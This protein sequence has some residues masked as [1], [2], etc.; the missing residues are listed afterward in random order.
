MAELKEIANVVWL[1]IGGG[2]DESRITLDEILVVA[3]VEYAFQ[4]LQLSWRERREEGFWNI[5]STISRES[6][7][8]KVINNEIDISKLKI[9]KAVPL[10]MWLQNIGGLTCSCFYI[11]TTI[12]QA[13]LMCDDDSLP[14]GTK[15]YY[16][17]G[18]K[19]KFP[20]GTHEDKLTIIYA[21]SGEDLDDDISIDDA[22]AAMIVEKL[23]SIYGN[24]II[25]ED[26]TNDSNSSINKQP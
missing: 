6:E 22:V 21:S 8:L 2:T 11:Q 9:L 19:I 13:Q 4:A 12:N 18:N 16:V 14:D 26:E 1:K 24:N 25:P 23:I 3:K 17:V 5:P 15:T 10:E 7:P 20:N